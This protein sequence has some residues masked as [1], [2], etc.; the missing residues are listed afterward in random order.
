L[1]QNPPRLTGIARYPDN[2]KI[3]STLNEETRKALQAWADE[4]FRNP[5]MVL[6][7]KIMEEA[8]GLTI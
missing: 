4:A 7:S 2:G 8:I 6:A 5:G 3:D 1:P